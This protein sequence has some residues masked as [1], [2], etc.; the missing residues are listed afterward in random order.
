MGRDN[1]LSTQPSALS[2]CDLC[3]FFAPFAFRESGL[4]RKERKV[5]AK[6][7]KDLKLNAERFF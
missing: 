7:A 1:C 2:L 3:D 5:I 4:K 6:V